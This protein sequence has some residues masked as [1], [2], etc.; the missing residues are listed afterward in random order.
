MCPLT[1]VSKI[2]IYLSVG[3]VAGFLYGILPLVFPQNVAFNDDSPI[4][5]ND[6]D[7]RIFRR[8]G[9][10]PVST[11]ALSDIQV[12]FILSTKRSLEH[13]LSWSN[14]GQLTN[15]MGIH[16]DFQV[17]NSKTSTDSFIPLFWRRNQ[18]EIEYL[19]VG[20]KENISSSLKR[21][22]IEVLFSEEFHLNTV[23]KTEW[24]SVL[25]QNQAKLL[26]LDRTGNEYRNSPLPTAIN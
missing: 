15:S 2:W 6:R 14:V 3:L 18:K 26:P 20:V 17:K 5:F 8:S 4:K 25:D 9:I 22:I 24:K 12:R 10:V 21:R 23:Q 11:T 7:I 1:K 13:Q 16:A 19:L